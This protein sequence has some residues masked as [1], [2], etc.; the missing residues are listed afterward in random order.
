MIATK[1]DSSVGREVAEHVATPLPELPV[2]FV[3]KGY[4]R[5]SESFIAQEI[6]ALEAR[7]LPIHIVSLRHPTD[8]H[9]HPVHAHIKAPVTYLPEYLHDEPRRVW[10]AWRAARLLPGYAAA[11]ALWSADLR[12][13]WSRNRIRRFGQAL[14]LATELG[15]SVGHLHAHFLH[16]PSSVTRYAATMLGR[17]WTFSAHARDIWTSADWELREKLRDAAW[18]VTCT[19]LNHTH[20]NALAG[21][22]MDPVEL[23]YHGLDLQRFAYPARDWPDT[24]GTDPAAPVRLVSVGRAVEKKGYRYLLEALAALD[25]SLHWHLTHIGGGPLLEALKAQAL[26]LGID[27]RIEWAGA[28]P[29]ADVLAAYRC[30]DLFVLAS[31]VAGDGDRDGLPNVLVE[32]QSQALPAVATELS[33]IPELLSEGVNGL[34]VPPGDPAALS[35]ALRRLISAPRLRRELGEAGAARVRSALS[36][37][38]T[39]ERLLFRLGSTAVSADARAS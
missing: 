24:D 18:G 7:G 32:A 35:A 27:D 17:V 10:R 16:T 15:P 9:R 6:H 5:L 2:A 12:R 21:A 34:M 26:R 36:M 28:L 11:H 4:P 3:L 8:R 20:L 33:A 1:V 37:D 14:V 30:A 22:D 19:A 31:I 39:V 13:D 38:G 29:Q 23:M 25:K